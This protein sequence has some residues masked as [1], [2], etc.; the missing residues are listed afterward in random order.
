MI[1]NRRLVEHLG[2]IPGITNLMMANEER[3]LDIIILTN[4]DITRVDSQATEVRQTIN[5][6]ADLLLDCFDT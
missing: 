3:N 1:G 6:L 4:G 2:S 5:H